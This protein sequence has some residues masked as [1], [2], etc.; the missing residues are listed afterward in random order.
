MSISC[1][2][3]LFFSSLVCF[4]LCASADELS[5]LKPLVEYQWINPSVGQ[6]H[7]ELQ[8]LDDR[9][10]FTYAQIEVTTLDGN[11]IQIIPQVIT[12]TEPHFEFIDLNDDG[13]ID[14]LFYNTYA[15]FGGGP[16]T[17][18]DVFLYTPKLK[19]FAKSDTLS[20][21]GE[22]TKLK[23]K[24]CVNVNYKSGL[25]GYTDEQWCFNVKAGRWK[26]IKT[27]GGEPTAE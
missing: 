23:Q 27:S 18:A 25:A 20:G 26:M 14:M 19:K 17:G 16:T 8:I 12:F 3:K 9:Y 13:Y 21:Q 15:G 5:K 7:F 4:S 1:I 22:I 6:L 24:R 10:Q 2:H 11:L